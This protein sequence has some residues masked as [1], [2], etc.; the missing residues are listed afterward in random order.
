MKRNSSEWHAGQIALCV[1]A[2]LVLMVKS[3]GVVET[4]RSP[5]VAPTG[6]SE[7][8]SEFYEIIES[9]YPTGPYVEL[10]ARRQHKGWDAWGNE[11]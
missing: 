8:P 5:G 10:F 4:A 7:K 11:L 1:L 6:H 9:M 3:P 2:V